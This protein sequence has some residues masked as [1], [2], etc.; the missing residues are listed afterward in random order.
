[1]AITRVG[2]IKK[3][4]KESLIKRQVSLLLQQ[5][6]L[7]YPQLH[8]FSVT[9]VVLSANKRFASI[10]LFSPNGHEAFKQQ[11]PFLKL[12]APSLRKALAEAIT[13]KYVPE[14]KF[15]YDDVQEKQQA[16]ERLLDQIKHETHES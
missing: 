1:M 11:L 8:E 9:R 14:V 7:D 3:S 5:A 15:W 4:Q 16:I 6:A 2:F 10:F 13:S 12:L